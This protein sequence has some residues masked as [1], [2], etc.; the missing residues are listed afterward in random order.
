MATDDCQL[1]LQQELSIV[2]CITALS[3]DPGDG[4]EINPP[5]G[6]LKDHLSDASLLSCNNNHMVKLARHDRFIYI[7]AKT[8]KGQSECCSSEPLVPFRSR[9][10]QYWGPN[11]IVKLLNQ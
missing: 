1:H 5:A 2:H 3:E 10:Q 8:A 11:I 6:I 7:V 9:R 4:P